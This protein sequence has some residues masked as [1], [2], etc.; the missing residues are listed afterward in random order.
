MLFIYLVA[1]INKLSVLEEISNSLGSSSGIRPR[2]IFIISNI[3]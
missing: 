1:G 3:K 2:V